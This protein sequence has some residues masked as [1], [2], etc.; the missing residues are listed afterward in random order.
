MAIKL[1]SPDG[2][3]T[4]HV[5]TWPDR[6]PAVVAGR[7]PFVVVEDLDARFHGHGDSRAALLYFVGVLEKCLADGG[8]VSHVADE[9]VTEDERPYWFDD[10]EGG[11]A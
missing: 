8:T 7:A 1:T 6:L 5:F 4:M 3:Q 2:Q 11:L 10:D 9:D